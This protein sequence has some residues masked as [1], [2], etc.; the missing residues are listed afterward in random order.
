MTTK[1][2][3]A[4]RTYNGYQ[5]T[6]EQ[7][8][9]I[10]LAMTNKN[11]KIE[12]YAGAGKTSTLA[13]ISSAM[14]ERSGIYIA[15]NR[16][17][18]DEAARTF[19]DNVDCRTAHSLA[20]QA[21]G[22]LYKNRLQKRLTGGYL[23][24]E[25]LNITNANFIYNA[26]TV[27]AFGNLVLDTIN[28]FC[29]SSDLEINKNNLP[30]RSLLI[31]DDKNIRENVANEVVTYAKKTWKLMINVKKNI[32]VSHDLYLK[33]WGLSEPKIN[34]DFILFDEAQDASPVMLDIVKNQAAQQIY[35]G[36]R[37][38]QIYSF[39]GAVNA[40][41]LIDTPNVCKISQSFRFGQ[42]IANI[43]NAILN[44]NLSANVC[45]FGFD[46][47]DS[48]LTFLSKPDV[49]LFRTNS[50]LIDELIYQI[51]CGKCVFVFGGCKEMIS[52]IKAAQELKEKGKTNHYS[53]MLFKSWDEFVEFSKTDN[54]IDLSFLVK[55]M[56]KFNPDDLLEK[57][58]TAQRIKEDQADLIISTAH[59]A[60]GREWS[61]VK[62][63]NDFFSPDSEKSSREE[64]NLLYVA[65]TRA[66]HKL[67]IENCEAVKL[68]IKKQN[69]KLP[70][71]N[72]F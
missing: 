66:K 10:D 21:V 15:F 3:S 61:L 71:H 7:C 29:H 18:A 9:A 42:P 39:R 24:T 22:Y 60:K 20:F 72:I 34:R 12:A 38:Q 55:L 32:P 49:I 23:A 33:L 64:V 36:D 11:L 28:R 59:K 54:G 67:D 58:E 70:C 52:L 1:A 51:N 50:A 68:A 48:K 44:H 69:N 19:P 43:A 17:I 25:Y 8:R 16:A 57:L 30:W 63:A 56:R 62:L 14:P 46:G 35:V 13:A 53:L 26:I 4:I 40:M 37:Y 2:T 45:I 6:D 65:V 41:E 47:I 31:I 27:A 5:L